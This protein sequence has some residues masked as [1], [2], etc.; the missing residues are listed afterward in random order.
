MFDEYRASV[1]RTY[2]NKQAAN[3]LEPNLMRPTPK[4]L[5]EECLKLYETRYLKK[6]EKTIRAFFGSNLD[7]AEY[8]KTIGKFDLDKFK[9]LD[10]FLKGKTTDPEEK[11]IELLAWL[12]DY[13]PRPHEYG[14]TY[15]VGTLAETPTGGKT[16]IKDS[17]S[18]A[19]ATNGSLMKYIV[20]AIVV[21]IVGIGGYF[22]F[23]NRNKSEVQ[24]NVQIKRNG[25]CMYWA[26]DHYM[27]GRCDLKHGDTP[28][29]AL[30]SEK[31][32]NFKKVTDTNSISE[33]S[34]RK[35]WYVKIDKKLE[36]FTDSGFHPIDTGIRL[37]PLT[38]Y[39]VDK[40]VLHHKNR[41]RD[42]S[43]H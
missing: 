4:K 14:E 38:K 13:Q 23:A 8:K 36:L 31:L 22:L 12:I 20:L 39:M 6:D 25:K 2:K 27:P 9:P 24:G 5:R 34:V 21:I 43:K 41:L 32:I 37:K 30:D 19:P 35:V 40:Y 26:G 11:N 33:N 15:P 3:T 28:V 42:S 29:V 10:N 17:A 7:K 1:L 16:E 18:A